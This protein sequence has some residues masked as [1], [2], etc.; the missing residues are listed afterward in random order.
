M[1][2][3]RR[4][5]STSPPNLRP[6][7]ARKSSNNGGTSGAKYSQRQSNGEAYQHGL[8][9]SITPSMRPIVRHSAYPYRETPR[10]NNTADASFNPVSRNGRSAFGLK[11]STNISSQPGVDQID[12]SHAT[13]TTRASS[14]EGT[15]NSAHSPAL[16]CN[17]PRTRGDSTYLFGEMADK[18][19]FSDSVSDVEVQANGISGMLLPTIAGFEDDLNDDFSFY[20]SGPVLT[21]SEFLACIN[22][23]SAPASGQDATTLTQNNEQLCSRSS[24]GSMGMYSPMPTDPSR[25]KSPEGGLEG[26]VPCSNNAKTCMVS[27]IRILQVLHSPPPTCINSLDGPSIST[28]RQPRM[29]DSVLS[30]SRNVIQLVTDILKCTCSLRSQVQLLLTII[31][32]KL[33]AWYRAMLCNDS[34]AV[35][36][37]I[38]YNAKDEQHTERVVHQP[39]T[40][41]E[42]CFDGALESKLQAQVVFNEIQYLD[43]LVETLSRRIRGDKFQKVFSVSTTRTRSA[44][45]ADSWRSTSLPEAGLPEKI[46][47]SLNAFLQKQLRAVTAEIKF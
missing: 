30:T 23:H 40:V 39:I 28:H 33:M 6:P 22:D 7:K 35:P 34:S 13:P 9:Y 26:V 11:S 8:N 38:H 45:A 12:I 18:R 37:T 44:S 42:Y 1:E 27:A 19:I 21:Q 29:V 25:T 2:S 4:R 24:D 20:A 5:S 10:F 15:R 47:R 31:C 14:V 32:G 16:Q 43:G 17:D 36:P 46:Q 41:G 3:T